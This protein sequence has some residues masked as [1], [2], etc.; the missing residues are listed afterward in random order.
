[1][2]SA[3]CCWGGEERMRGRRGRGDSWGEIRQG[4]VPVAAG[5]PGKAPRQPP[6]ASVSGTAQ[7]WGLGSSRGRADGRI[8]GSLAEPP[9]P[10][11]P[12]AVLCQARMGRGPILESEDNT[13]L[14]PTPPRKN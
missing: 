9:L 3:H 2:F 7:R 14:V 8:A 10:A 11:L 13:G 12:V 5:G 1:M 4:E 6:S